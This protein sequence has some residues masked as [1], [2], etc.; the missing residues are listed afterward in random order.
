M[1]RDTKKY[2]PSKEDSTGK[3]STTQDKAR[4]EEETTTNKSGRALNIDIEKYISPEFHNKNNVYSM[5]TSPEIEK[6]L[7][8]EPHDYTIE[9]TNEPSKTSEIRTDFSSMELTT[10]QSDFFDPKFRMAVDR[11]TQNLDEISSNTEQFKQNED[12]DNEEKYE[13]SKL[14]DSYK[15]ADNDTEISL[16]ANEYKNID[17]KTDKNKHGKGMESGKNVDYESKYF[18]SQVYGEKPEHNNISETSDLKG[19][20][21]DNENHETKTMEVTDKTTIEAADTQIKS[22]T[23]TAASTTILP[24]KKSR[25][26]VSLRNNTIETTAPDSDIKPKSLKHFADSSNID[27]LRENEKATY[28][29]PAYENAINIS[30]RGS[31][32]FPTSSEKSPTTGTSG[33]L[34]AITT[35]EK[36]AA[37]T[38]SEKYTPTPTSEKSTA[39]TIASFM[40]YDNKNFSIPPTATA[41]TLVSLKDV[42]LSSTPSLKDN[43]S[44]I[45][46]EQNSQENHLVKLPLTTPG[47][48]VGTTT[49]EKVLETTKSIENNI[50]YSTTTDSTDPTSADNSESGS[51]KM[52]K[53]TTIMVTEPFSTTLGDTTETDDSNEFRSIEDITSSTRD[54][55]TKTDD[56]DTTTVR[57]AST[58]YEDDLLENLEDST[59]TTTFKIRTTTSSTEET[60]V[61]ST[62]EIPTT[63]EMP[64]TTESY[65]EYKQSNEETTTEI[66]STESPEITITEASLIY[67]T[68][69][70]TK[71]T[72][73]TTSP[74][75]HNTFSTIVEQSGTT[76]SVTETT[77]KSTTS[78]PL[79]EEDMDSGGEENDY[80]EVMLKK[81]ITDTNDLEI[82][83]VSVEN[84]QQST[85]TSSRPTSPPKI[86]YI[87]TTPSSTFVKDSKSVFSNTENTTVDATSSTESLSHDN[88]PSDESNTGMIAAITISSIGGVCLILLAGLLVITLF[89]V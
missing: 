37:I 45:E 14:I 48:E 46:V 23:L 42:P 29:K 17:L 28:T 4:S 73:K 55:T 27:P 10:P 78:S 74:E 35:S 53:Q 64:T 3:E 60:T 52:V 12:E 65:F 33:K 58:K 38:T 2:E 54:E 50:D 76:K 71:N 63:T 82:D 7:D 51:N 44:L 6:Y 40:D 22:Q 84:T 70:P 36:S 19:K 24:T 83:N 21:V 80:S 85:Q 9:V 8:S 34:A 89:L 88:D 16:H 43:Q 59:E 49:T 41:W 31:T 75:L 79:E 62:T 20:T 47:K 77:K 86:V 1:L 72:M 15:N 39:T 57:D 13:V 68:L 18:K 26:Q 61:Y 67:T 69:I 56:I 81:N 30:K 66:A 25:T 5:P 87:P 32:K 11:I